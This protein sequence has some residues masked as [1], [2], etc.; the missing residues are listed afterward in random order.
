MAAMSMSY[1]ESL[2]GFPFATLRDEL[3]QDIESRRFKSAAQQRE[4]N[5]LKSQLQDKELKRSNDLKSIIGYYY[6][7]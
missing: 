5:Q 6:K 3:Y 4:I 7:R 1:Y 2:Y